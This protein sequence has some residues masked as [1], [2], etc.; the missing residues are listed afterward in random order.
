MG[1]RLAPLCI[2]ASLNSPI[3]SPPHNQST[4]EREPPITSLAHNQII[5]E[6]PS[7]PPSPQLLY[8]GGDAGEP[9]DAVHDSLSL[10]ELRAAPQD[11][12]DLVAGVEEVLAEVTAEDPL[13]KDSALLQLPPRRP[14]QDETPAE[15]RK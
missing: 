4:G 5:G 10:Q 12:R 14:R 7:L 8:V 13:P 2:I 3:T 9:V 15:G 6:R 1:E 11:H